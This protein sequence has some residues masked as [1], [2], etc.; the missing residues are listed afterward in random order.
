MCC[1]WTTEIKDDSSFSV[2][3]SSLGEFAG[4]LIS[5]QLSCFA[6][7]IRLSP[8]R[9]KE[10]PIA[11]EFAGDF[12]PVEPALRGESKEFTRLASYGIKSLWPIFKTKMLIFS[13]RLS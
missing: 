12:A 3:G 10:I 4:K 6:S 8:E 1:Y 9:A 2:I 13:I 7:K 11:D 5:F